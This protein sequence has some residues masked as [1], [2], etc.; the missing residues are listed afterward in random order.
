MAL[1]YVAII[2]VILYFIKRVFKKKKED[3]NPF[4]AE[5]KFN[6]EKIDIFSEDGNK[7]YPG[8]IEKSYEY[9]GEGELPKRKRRRKNNFLALVE[10]LEKNIQKGKIA[11]TNCYSLVSYIEEVIPK[12]SLKSYEIMRKAEDT[13]L[14]TIEELNFI[15]EEFLKNCEVDRYWDKY[16]KELYN[17]DYEEYSKGKINKEELEKRRKYYFGD[18]EK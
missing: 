7:S 1:Y 10:R 4:G 2:L 17:Q 6:G 5:V 15:K 14:I 3:K 9:D 8:I 11:R 13:L 18:E 12:N 16:Y